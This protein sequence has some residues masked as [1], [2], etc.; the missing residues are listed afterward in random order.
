MEPNAITG[1]PKLGLDIDLSKSLSSY[2]YIAVYDD[3]KF[4]K[5]F[6]VAK[7]LVIV[8]GEEK[9]VLQRQEPIEYHKYALPTNEKETGALLDLFSVDI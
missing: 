4:E 1:I 7:G 9:V 5:H 3:P 2:V 8:C 6:G